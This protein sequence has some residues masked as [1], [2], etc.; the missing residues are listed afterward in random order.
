MQNDDITWE[1]VRKYGCSFRFQ[2]GANKFCRNEFNVDGL[3]TRRGCP[4]ANSKYATVREHKGNIFLYI[5]YP[6]KVFTPRYQWKRI[7]LSKN[8]IEAGQTLE[9]ELVFWPEFFKRKCRRRLLKIRTY[10]SRMR[11]LKLHV[12]KEIVPH[13]AKR[14]LLLKKKEEKALTAAKLEKSLEQALVDRL[15]AGTYSNLYNFEEKRRLKKLKEDII[16]EEKEDR[17]FEESDVEEEEEE[18]TEDVEDEEEEISENEEEAMMDPELRKELKSIRLEDDGDDETDESDIS[19]AEEE[20][21]GTVRYVEDFEESD[22][23]EEE[24]LDIEDMD[25]L[26]A[27]VSKVRVGPGRTQLS[28]IMSEGERLQLNDMEMEDLI[29]KRKYQERKPGDERKI[30][31]FARKQALA[32][33]NVRAIYEKNLRQKQANREKVVKRK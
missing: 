8:M 9:D 28:T 27:S 17:M 22:E 13:R 33:K 6:E 18:E 10:M 20:E 23:E 1:I 16:R 15:A 5:R 25:R 30:K 24:P 2:T 21:D 31:R 32:K 7:K 14:E 26:E 4:L 19:S 3:C 11:T 29:K 12:S